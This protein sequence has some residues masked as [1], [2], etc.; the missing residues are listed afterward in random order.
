MTQNWHACRFCSEIDNEADRDYAMVKYS[1]R[2]YAHFACYLD[3]GK[4]LSDLHSWQVAQFPYRLLKERGLLD[5]PAVK[6]AAA[7][8]AS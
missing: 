1:T 8:V 6:A 3:A 4:K 2:H 5:D 7:E